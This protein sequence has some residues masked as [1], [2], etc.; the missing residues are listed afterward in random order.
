MIEI[1][2]Q[3][4]HIIENE[5]YEELQNLK[6]TKPEYFN[7][8]HEIFEGIHVKERPDKAALIWADG[9]E[10]VYYTYQNLMDKC[11]QL[12]N[13]LREKGVKK[14]DIILTQL[15]LQ[16]IN[17][18]ATLATI[19]G[20][21]CMIPTA[22]IMGPNDL[23]FR[24]GK[25]LPKVVISDSDNAYKTDEAEEKLGIKRS[26]ERRVGK[27]GRSRRRGCRAQESG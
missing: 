5:S 10:T 1:Y 14:D 9:S 24:F 23:A 26:E 16:L 8:V 12:L 25:T 21:F 3:L 19:K 11:N 22:T 18:Y 13:F 15:L 6:I 2:K 4:T 27:E 7:W 17:W 20:G